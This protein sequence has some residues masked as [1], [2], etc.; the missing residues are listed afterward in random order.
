MA[1][2]LCFPDLRWVPFVCLK[3][4]LPWVVT[5]AGERMLVEQEGDAMVDVFEV[6]DL[7]VSQAVANYGDEVD[8]IAYY[9][10]QARGEAQSGSDLDFFYTPA[11]GKNP[12]IGRTFLL[13]ELLF[14]FWAL[15][16]ETL[17]GFA[18][19]TTRGWAFAPAL[20]RQA[21]PLYVRSPDQADRLA[22]L[23]HQS[24][25]LEAPEYRS[26]MISRAQET[27]SRVLEQLGS[28]RLA[29]QGSRTD[30]CS[31][32]WKLLGSI[33]ECL[34]LS[35]QVTFERGFH[36]ALA[37]TERFAKRPPELDRL[38]NII[39]TSPDV[40]Q[41]LQAADELVTGVYHTLR[42]S[43]PARPASVS[44]RE[45]F[46]EVYPEMKD[47]VRKLLTACEAGDRVA[48][49]LEA[50]SLQ[51]HITSMLADTQSGVAQRRL[52]LRKEQSTYDQAGFPDLMAL[53]FGPLDVLADAARLFDERLRD[54][55]GKHGVDLCEFATLEELRSTL[56]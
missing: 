56:D 30:V 33:W 27:F 6:A 47:I 55:L 37:E 5:R 36:R 13:N 39:S 48:A 8:L 26:A 53:S 50:H 46:A 15:R 42:D 34:A 4:S 40:N 32:A 25:A 35:N 38:L 21:T 31:A 18:T 23:Q 51:D 16:W 43:E 19:G 3:Q 14:D 20:V 24:L 52:A 11:E 17:E 45:Q 49:S 54:W 10:S 9:G 29:A 2:V 22:A 12:L 28:L 41:V 44:I 1:V 7:L